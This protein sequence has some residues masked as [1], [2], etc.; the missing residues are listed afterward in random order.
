MRKLLYVVLDGLG[1]LPTPELNGKTPLEAAKTPNMDSLAR[2]GKTGLMYPVRKGVAPE[3]DVAVISIL[4]YDPFKY[5]P[6][7][8][9]IEAV[10]AGLDFKDGELALRCNFATIDEAGKFIV[11]RRVGRNL[12]TEEA[13][14][15]AEAINREVKL[16]YKPSEFI[17]KN[18]VAHRAVLVIRR[19]EGK[20]S[21]KITNV[22]P[23]YSKTLEGF[24]V[25]KSQ[26]QTKIEKCFP[27]DDSEEARVAAEL[28]NEFI[29][30]SYKVL[31]N[32]ELNLR[33][34]KEGKLPA[35]FILARDAGDTIPKFPSFQ[36]LYKVKFGCMADMPVERGIALLCG[37]EEVPLPQSTG[38]L[39]ADYS[40]RAEKTLEA[41][42]SLDGV[43]IHIKGPDEPG[44]DGRAKEKMRIVELIDE[45]YFG[46]LLAK[47]NLEET[48]IVVT[49]DHAT[50][51]VIKAHTDDPVP[52]LISGGGVLADEVDV[53]SEKACRKG[54][55]GIINGSELMPLLIKLLKD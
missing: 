35:N 1:D 25:A 51:C 17:F 50:P 19:L 23:A 36:E 26:P 37:M 3:S 46:K 5:H 12:T 4:G 27:L 16:A 33:R 21:G 40:L 14:K 54:R 31:K 18:T 11:D 52:L 32:H 34:V 38:D 7:R 10:G 9:V 47:L 28:V 41:L 55:L 45:F 13:G 24:G 39:K 49:A 42:E 44:H 43:Y 8:G 29:E 15:L 53:F 22:D 30:K 2:K 20:L 6:A 48:L